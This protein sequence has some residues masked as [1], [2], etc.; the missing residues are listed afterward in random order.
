MAL[1]RGARFHS[2]EY[3]AKARPAKKAPMTAAMPI[4]SAA[5]ESTR[6]RAR[7]RISGAFWVDMRSTPGRILWITFDA[8]N[9][10]KTVN[11]TASSNSTMSCTHCT[12]A[13][14]PKPATTA[15]AIMPRMSSATAGPG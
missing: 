13:L 10:M 8:K 9:I 14:A 1:T 6:Q 11:A 12:P 2:L 7:A 5:T 3:S 4:R 15:S